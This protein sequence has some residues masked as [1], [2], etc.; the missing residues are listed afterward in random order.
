MIAQHR[1]SASPGHVDVAPTRNAKEHIVYQ[2]SA[3]VDRF[4]NEFEE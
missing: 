2:E 4:L 3:K 1:I